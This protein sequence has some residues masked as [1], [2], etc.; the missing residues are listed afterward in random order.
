MANHSAER[1]HILGGSLCERLLPAPRG[2]VVHL[3]RC[4]DDPIEISIRGRYGEVEALTPSDA[5]RLA[6][7]LVE[8]A[9]L[10]DG[11]AAQAGQTSPSIEGLRRAQGP[12]DGAPVGTGRRGLATL[13]AVATF[14]VPP[15][16]G[17]EHATDEERYLWLART[18][19]C[20]PL[21]PGRRIR[22][23]TWESRHGL[24]TA[25]VGGQL[26][27]VRQ[28]DRPHSRPATVRDPATVLAIFDGVV[29]TDAT[30]PGAPRSLWEPLIQTGEVDPD[31]VER[32]S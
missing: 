6:E 23:T 24:M 25:T 13:R 17:M 27:G 9:R 30:L 32:F 11:T 28:A 29:V 5:V 4:D 1:D 2:L 20:N 15:F 26:A 21:P 14:F 22:S 31:D 8:A 12:G 3:T 7:V 18:W 19:G 10:A 16:A